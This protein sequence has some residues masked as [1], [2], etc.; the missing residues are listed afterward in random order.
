MKNDK[1]L[2]EE[3][4]G[5]VSS[6][7]IRDIYVSLSN[8]QSNARVSDQTTTCWNPNANAVVFMPG[9]RE[10][11]R[12]K[13]FT[14]RASSLASACRTPSTRTTSTSSSSKGIER[15]EADRVMVREGGALPP[16]LREEED[17]GTEYG[18][19]PCPR[20]IERA[21]GWISGP[22]AG[23]I[24]RLS[25][26]N[27]PKIRFNERKRLRNFFGKWLACERRKSAMKV[28][29]EYVLTLDVTQRRLWRWK[30]KVASLS[31]DRLSSARQV[32]APRRR[33]MEPSVSL[34]GISIS[35]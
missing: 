16:T 27:T 17:K 29:D 3:S 10:P 31:H 7:K 34:V 11:I 25:P 4:L 24:F 23:S 8:I 26:S 6:T 14:H 28:S 13:I 15:E 19:L 35:A 32:S 33:P 9:Q 2:V 18:E 21:I 20:S 12:A 30:T 5:L 1:Q 22:R